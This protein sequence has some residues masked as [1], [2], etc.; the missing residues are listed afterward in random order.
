MLN[1]EPLAA[2]RMKLRRAGYFPVPCEGK[3]PPVKGWQDL[4]ET[5]AEE[6]SLW[7]KSW[8]MA[9]NTG[10]LG[11][12][13]PGLDAD[14][15]DEDACEAIETLVGQMFEDG[16]LLVRI[17]KAPKRLIP[18]CT[19]LAVQEADFLAVTA[20]N[21][22]KGKIEFLGHGQHYVVDGFHPETKSAYCWHGAGHLADVSAHDLPLIRD[23]DHAQ[24]VLDALSAPMLVAD[25]GYT[26][27]PK[28]RTDILERAVKG[29]TVNVFPLHAAPTQR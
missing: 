12:H 15:L 26:L 17:G 29:E 14:L 28:Q 6:I 1:R 11:Q 16:R 13:A 2:L 23:A 20:P 5:N 25:H 19:E 8:H 7:S 9:R 21:G 27:E 24:E 3:R 4:F 22:T 18:F 10:V